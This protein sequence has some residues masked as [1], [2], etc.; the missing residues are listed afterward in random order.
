MVGKPDFLAGN[1]HFPYGNF[2]PDSYGKKPNYTS[3][4]WASQT[5]LEAVARPGCASIFGADDS[6]CSL[7]FFPARAHNNKTRSLRLSHFLSV[8]RVQDS[9]SQEMGGLDKVLYVYFFGT[10]ATGV[11]TF[12]WYGR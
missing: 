10:L 12:A 11:K 6:V 7:L 9:R 2:R 4:Q 5:S 3:D 8:V 1:L